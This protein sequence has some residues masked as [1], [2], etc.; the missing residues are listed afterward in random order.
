MIG[1]PF[2]K[3]ATNY[4]EHEPHKCNNA[5]SNNYNNSVIG[6]TAS[7]IIF[8]QSIPYII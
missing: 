3:M 2:I 4:V 6:T 8:M 1:L 5:I 7:N